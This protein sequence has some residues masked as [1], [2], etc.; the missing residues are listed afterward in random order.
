MYVYND[1]TTDSRVLREAD[2]LAA[3]GHQVTIMA[4]A[5]SLD[6]RTV[7]RE[8]RGS[9]EIVRVAVPVAWRRLWD[10][11]FHPWRFR[12]LARLVLLPWAAVRVPFHLAA[13]PRARPG[14]LMWLA[15]WRFA[16]RGWAVDA[17]AAAPPADIHHGHD[18][19]GLA[20][21]VV[22]RTATTRPWCTT[23]MRS[24]SR[25]EPPCANLPGRARSSRGSSVD[26][27]A[28]AARW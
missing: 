15:T 12:G 5:R 19:T 28:R 11:L 6:I 23:A 21:A 10:V 7:E 27:P 26:G 1:V 24:T 4:R 25:R 22:G 9:I 17:A 2:A 16:I 20:A 14:V 8:W 3:A 18:L 13:R